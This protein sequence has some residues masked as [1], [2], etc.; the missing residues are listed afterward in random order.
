MELWHN[1]LL[2]QGITACQDLYFSGQP[3]Q[4]EAILPLY[5]SQTALLSRQSSPI[6]QEAAKL[7]SLAHLLA[8]ELFADRENFGAAEQA[9]KTAFMYGQLAGDVN[10]QVASLIGLGNIAFHRKLSSIALHVFQKAISLMDHATPLLKGR[11]Y[12]GIAEVY[13]MRGQFQETMR[14]LGLAYQ[15]FPLEPEKDPAYPYLRASRYALYVF[16][17]AQSRLFLN[18]PKEANEALI[19]MEKETNDPEIEPI[20]KLDLLYYQAEVQIQKRE[21]DQS[22]IILTEAATLAKDL[23]SRLYFDKLVHSFNELNVKWPKERRITELEELFLPWA[24]ELPDS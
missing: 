20:T 3:H 14:A 24:I 4:I 23:G 19:A 12:A 10:L 13:A 9:G 17:D 7:A 11:T 6:Q 1:D 5:C 16:G 8:C 22:I 15:Y 21:M 18:Q 2:S